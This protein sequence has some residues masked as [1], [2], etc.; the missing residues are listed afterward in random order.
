[1]QL[2][3]CLLSGGTDRSPGVIQAPSRP[4]AELAYAALRTCYRVI[5][6]NACALHGARLASLLTG[7]QANQCKND[8]KRSSTSTYHV[9]SSAFHFGTWQSRRGRR[10]DKWGGKTLILE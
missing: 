4:Q 7:R 1:M 5:D 10:K 6:S 8:R 2:G 3:T 9:A